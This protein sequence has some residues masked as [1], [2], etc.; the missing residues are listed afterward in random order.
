[1]VTTEQQQKKNHYNKVIALFFS[2]A[3]ITN[4]NAY[5]FQEIIILHNSKNIPVFEFHSWRHQ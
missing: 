4:F 2:T 3:W 5:L 1:M